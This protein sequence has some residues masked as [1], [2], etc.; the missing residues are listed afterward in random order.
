MRPL[1]FSFVPLY[2]GW[3]GS[4]KNTTSGTE[5][6]NRECCANSLP[7]SRVMVRRIALG[8]SISCFRIFPMTGFNFRFDT[9]LIFRSQMRRSVLHTRP[10]RLPGLTILSPSQSPYLF[11]ASAATGRP[12]IEI[13]EGNCPRLSFLGLRLYRRGRNA[14]QC[15][16]CKSFRIHR[17]NVLH[18]NRFLTSSESRLIRPTTY[19][20]DQYF[21][22]PER[23]RSL[24]SGTSIFI[25]NG[26]SDRR[27]SAIG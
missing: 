20:G 27:S 15:L 3:L 14:S 9:L 26:R 24:N 10:L 22:M 1:V 13:V 16:R 18:D 19:S 12:A 5:Y 4:A 2:H 6:T 11:R 8:R 21:V 7:F 17:S 25:F 23:T